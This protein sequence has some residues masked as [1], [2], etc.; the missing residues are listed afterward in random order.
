[1]PEKGWKTIQVKEEYLSRLR[2]IYEREKHNMLDIDV[3]TFN[4]FVQKFFGV[5]LDYVEGGEI[6]YKKNLNIENK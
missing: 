3:R 2:E 4:G 5:S 1:M 6:V